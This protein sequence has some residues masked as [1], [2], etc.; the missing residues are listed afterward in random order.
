MKSNYDPPF[1]DDEER[2]FV[3]SIDEESF[4][5]A[6]TPKAEKQRE[7]KDAA[8]EFLAQ[9]A[10]MNIRIDPLE[11]DLIKERAAMEG[12]KYQ[13]FVKSVLYKYVTGQLV[14]APKVK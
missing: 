1:P 5:Q 8:R 11:L 13:T 14:D 2:E 10:K 7:W 6:K 4:K 3:E 9:N 12:L